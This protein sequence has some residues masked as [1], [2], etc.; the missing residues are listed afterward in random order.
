MSPTH[1]NSTTVSTTD[2]YNWTHEQHGK[3]RCHC[4]KYAA[5]GYSYRFGMLELLCYEHWKKRTEQCHLKKDMEKKPS[6]PISG[7]RSNQVS[8]ES[9]QSLLL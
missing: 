1:P 3:K 6:H 8:Q 2:F 7:K 9:K 5:F 4:G